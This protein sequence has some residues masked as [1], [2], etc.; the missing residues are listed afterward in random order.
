MPYRANGECCLRMSFKRK[1]AVSLGDRARDSGQWEL[2]IAHY[3]RGL[4]ADPKN[5]PIWVQYGHALKEAG[6]LLTAEI[7]YRK[8]IELG[9]NVADSHLQLGHVLKLQGR[10][11]DAKAAYLSAHS[12]D[13]ALAAARAELT[14]LGWPAAKVQPKPG[15]EAPQ[16]PMPVKLAQN[17]A[18][19]HLEVPSPERFDAARYL[20]N[21]PDVLRSGMD[22]LEHFL[23]YGRQEGRT[24]YAEEFGLNP[25]VR[26]SF[27]RDELIH[28]FR[29]YDRSEGLVSIANKLDFDNNVFHDLEEIWES[30]E[31]QENVIPLILQTYPEK[32]R[33]ISIHIPK[34]AGTHLWSRLYDRYISARTALQDKNYTTRLDLFQNLKVISILPGDDIFVHGHKPISWYISNELLRSTDSIFSVVREPLEIIVSF[35]NYII[36]RFLTDPSFGDA[37]TKEW[38]DLLGV[39]PAMFDQSPEGLHNLARRIVRQPLVLHRNPLCRYLGDGDVESALNTAAR[40]NIELTDVTRYDPWL[41]QKF[42]IAAGER[43]NVSKKIL[44]HSGLNADDKALLEEYVQE[45][46]KLYELIISALNKSRSLS[47]R[48]GDLI[49]RSS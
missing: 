25:R 20:A 8:A 6:D 15:P 44:T 9:P 1:N 17:V 10:L 33:I 41:E 19:W 48:G 2:A 47:V 21:H 46:R 38:A 24:A 45:D 18:D 5:A 11:E 26:D 13:P 14:A 29:F 30:R 34:C 4:A 23:K 35:I 28:S 37:D 7:A 16:A 31:F 36:T 22:P 39:T 40:S 32:K 3:R 27:I 42:G 43:V 12:L 49:N